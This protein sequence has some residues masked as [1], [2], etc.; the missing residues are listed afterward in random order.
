VRR[1]T[2]SSD[3]GPDLAER[4]GYLIELA[5]RAPS[6]HNTQPWRF[7]V[8]GQAIELYADPGRQLMEDLTGREMIISCGAALFG[9]R[10]AIRSLGCQP[11]VDLLP[12]PGQRHLLARVRAG[13][14]EPMASDERAMLRAVPHRH[15]HRGGFEPGPLPGGLLAWLQDDAT[16][17]GATLTA[18]G[19]GPA[20]DGWRRS[21]PDGAG[22]GTSTPPRPRRYGREPRRC[23]GPAGQAVR[24]G[25]ACRLM[26][27]RQVVGGRVLLSP[28]HAG[29]DGSRG[30]VEHREGYSGDR[31]VM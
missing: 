8:T 13:R 10:L 14:P 27:R 17:E 2:K 5:A 4:A 9:L 25:T 3:A 28:L 26:Q 29:P 1:V 21:S 15:T 6:V 18:I 30:G 22:G 16:A 11:E 7:S 31:D 12:G 24:P 23:A 20:H 19:G